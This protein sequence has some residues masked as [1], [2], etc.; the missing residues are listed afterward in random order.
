MFFSPR[1]PV[2]GMGDHFLLEILRL[3]KAETICCIYFLFYHNSLVE[4]VK[5]KNK[6]KKAG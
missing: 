2:V 4:V 6:Q 1:P 5:V 3:L